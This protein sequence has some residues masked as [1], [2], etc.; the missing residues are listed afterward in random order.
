MPNEPEMMD[1]KPDSDSNKI[2]ATGDPGDLLIVNAGGLHCAGVNQTHKPRRTLNIRIVPNGD[3]L[4]YN[5]WELAGP[6]LQAKASER[7]KRFMQP[8][9]D[10]V[11]DLRTDWRVTP[12]REKS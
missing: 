9:A 11:A 6:E 2:Q 8:P 4:F 5:A 3:R 10:R 1:S 7:V 12:R